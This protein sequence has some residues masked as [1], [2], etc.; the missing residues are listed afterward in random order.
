MNTRQQVQKQIETIEH[1]SV[2]SAVE[3][4]KEL[5]KYIVDDDPKN[6]RFQKSLAE[7][8]R[9][10]TERVDSQTIDNWSSYFHHLKRMETLR[11]L[12]GLAY[13]AFTN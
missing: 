12:K 1:L 8:W 5:S 4:M 11:K 3:F 9:A 10:T 13:P 6:N 7:V 2:E